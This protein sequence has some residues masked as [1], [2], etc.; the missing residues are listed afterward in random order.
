M[1]CKASAE[2]QYLINSKT[3]VFFLYEEMEIY[4]N[5]V[6]DRFDEPNDWLSSLYFSG[7]LQFGKKNRMNINMEAVFLSFILT[8]NNSII[9]NPVAGGGFQVSIQM[10][11]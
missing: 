2:L 5:E 10:P 6:I 1:F 4:E 9:N 11:F 7:G 3:D 8:N